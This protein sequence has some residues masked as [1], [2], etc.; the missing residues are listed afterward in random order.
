VEATKLRFRKGDIIL[1]R[2]RVCQCKVA[3]AN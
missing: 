1:G 3:V 2:R